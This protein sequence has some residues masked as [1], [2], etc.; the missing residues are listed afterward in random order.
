MIVAWQG[1]E[2]LT[3]PPVK[4]GCMAGG[5]WGPAGPVLLCIFVPFFRRG[6]QWTRQQSRRPPRSAPTAIFLCAL[7]NYISH[8]NFIMMNYVS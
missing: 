3:S 2:Q 1:R 7:S 4:T 5:T 8:M 6:S